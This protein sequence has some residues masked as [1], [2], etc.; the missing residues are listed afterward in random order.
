MFELIDKSDKFYNIVCKEAQNFNIINNILAKFPDRHRMVD[1]SYFEFYK[2]RV[3]IEYL[4]NNLDIYLYQNDIYKEI[5][6]KGF[7]ENEDDD[8][9]LKIKD[10]QYK[11]QP[12]KHQDFI[13]KKTAKKK[14]FALFMEQR[15]GKLFPTG[16]KVVTPT[17][18]INI[19]N[20]KIGDTVCSWEGTSKVTNKFYNSNAKI[21]RITFDNKDSIECCEDHLWWVKDSSFCKYVIRE[22]KRSGIRGSDWLVKS[23]KELLDEGL[24]YNNGSGVQCKRWELPQ[25]KPVEFAEQQLP[26]KPYTLGVLIGD[27]GLTTKTILVTIDNKDISILDRIEEDGYYV[28]RTPYGKYSHR[29]KIDRDIIPEEVKKHSYEKRI[30]KEYLFNTVENRIKLLQGLIDTDSWIRVGCRYSK[31]KDNY[32]SAAITYST[33][34]KLL[35]EDIKFLVESLGGI[36]TTW[37]VKMGSYVINGTKKFT[38]L[39]YSFTIRLPREIAIQCCTLKRKLDLIIND[40]STN[41]RLPKRRIVSIDYIGIKEGYC[42]EVNDKKSSYLVE[43]CLVT[44]NTKIVLD[45]AAYLYEN[46]KIETVV[47]VA[48]NVVHRDWIKEAASEHLSC[49]YQGIIWNPKKKTSTL[50]IEVLFNDSN[51]LN[52]FTINKEAIIT[53]DGMDCL[54]Y[55]V[56]NYKTMLVIDES[57]HFKNPLGKRTGCVKVVAMKCPYVRILTGTPIGN[58]LED[59]YSQFEIMDKNIL[60]YSSYS[61]FSKFCEDNL[62][63]AKEFVYNAIKNNF[64]RM[65]L[66]ECFD[67]LPKIAE[68]NNKFQMTNEQKDIYNQI[69][70]NNFVFNLEDVTLFKNVIIK[71]QQVT[72]G[73]YFDTENNVHKIFSSSKINPKIKLLEEQLEITS[74]KVLIWTKFKQEVEDIIEFLNTTN[75]RYVVYTGNQNQEEKE[76]AKKMFKENN[77]I[78][79]MVI[80]I[81]A[82]AEGLTLN[83]ANTAIF[84]SSTF[85]YLQDSQAR[86]RIIKGNDT[87]KKTIIRLC[88]IG[89]IDIRILYLL[90]RKRNL[91]SDIIDRDYTIDDYKFI[92]EDESDERTDNF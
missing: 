66:N 83:Q 80:N 11:T 67:D 84:Y 30:P 9:E 62:D 8:F 90:N 12:W 73:F 16:T 81:S 37:K 61:Q 47:V 42:L 15:T 50:E 44:H 41:K 56:K 59:L 91:S 40:K 74:G 49:D 28:N 33:S 72:S 20:I 46:K 23:T 60:G 52:I 3:N 26:V 53:E 6:I 63:K 92:L 32:Y 35:A 82:G 75:Y 79:I 10:Y 21:Y 5:F 78:K 58:K 55:I 14:K 24:Y 29:I 87:N 19:E 22:N 48:P 85:S 57:H 65:T 88:S 34:S 2:S 54:N 77:D 70:D 27:G 25:C 39:Q 43:N 76:F 71:L 17:G 38:R 7:E 18:H 1:N 4:K 31:I 68:I 69:K 64:I 45:T 36:V 89:T 86:Q 13:F 51:K